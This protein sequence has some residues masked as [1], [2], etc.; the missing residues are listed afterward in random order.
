MS[1]GQELVRAASASQEAAGAGKWRSNAGG[2]AADYWAVDGEGGLVTNCFMNAVNARDERA[3]KMVGVEIADRT[4]DTF[5]F[6]YLVEYVRSL[7][8][9]ADLITPDPDVPDLPEVA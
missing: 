9:W 3:N 6:Y 8:R 1:G 5:A 2:V 7:Y 4:T